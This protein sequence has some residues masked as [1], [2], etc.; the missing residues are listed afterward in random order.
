M[1]DSDRQEYIKEVFNNKKEYFYYRDLRLLIS[2]V[3]QAAK[4][5]GNLD[6]YTLK[7]LDI[8]RNM[9]NNIKQNSC[10]Y[11]DF[12]DIYVM[13]AMRDDAE[14]QK[15]YHQLQETL[16]KRIES[17]H[18]YDTPAE[19]IMPDEENRIFANSCLQRALSYAMI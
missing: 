12:G 3:S 14:F 1:R 5:Q 19:Q 8:Y 7:F 6:F 2:F 16:L 9:V 10:N 4:I 13:K 17:C 11:Y 15:T 18:K